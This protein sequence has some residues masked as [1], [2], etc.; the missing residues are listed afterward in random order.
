MDKT[1]KPSNP[2]Y[3]VF[4][5]FMLFSCDKNRE[6]PITLVTWS[7]AWTVF[8]GWNT[9]IVGSIPTRPMDLCVCLIYCVVLS[10][11]S[12]LAPGWSPIQGTLPTVY[13]IKKLKSGQVSA[14]NFGAVNN[15]N[16]N[17]EMQ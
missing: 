5:K 10:V 9:G 16:K 2:G 11:G 14:E 1:Q 13:R 12:G 6:T 4:I 15:D 17:L 7:K 3:S 8:A